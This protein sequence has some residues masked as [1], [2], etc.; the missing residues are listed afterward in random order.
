[1]QYI[2]VFRYTYMYYIAQSTQILIKFCHVER[3]KRDMKNRVQVSEKHAEAVIFTWAGLCHSAYQC[4]SPDMYGRSTS[5]TSWSMAQRTRMAVCAPE[6]S[7]S[8]SMARRWWESL[9]SWWCSSCSRRLNR[10]TST[11]PS[12]VKPLTEVQFLSHFVAR[13]CLA[14]V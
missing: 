11:S 10:V 14:V 12:A 8:A 6:M 7:S 2:S 1:M 4:S 13:F 3:V 5:G 9:T